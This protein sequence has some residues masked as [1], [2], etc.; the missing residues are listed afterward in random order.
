[1]IMISGLSERQ[2]KRVLIVVLIIIGVPVVLFLC[3]LSTIA[4]MYGPTYAYRVLIYNEATI[5]DYKRVFPARAVENQPPVF[6][7]KMAAQPLQI[8][9]VTYTYPPG[10][11]TTI[12]FEPYLAQSGST[13]FIVIKDD[14]ILYEKYLNGYQR[15]SINRSFSMAKSIT[16]TLVGLAVQDGY[17]HSIDDTM[18]KYLPELKGRGLDTMTIRDLLVMNSGVAFNLLP[19]DAFILTQPFYDEA[20]MY[21]MPN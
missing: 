13:A 5:E 11:T 3:L 17:I 8:G 19:R 10:N 7:F 12:D 9:K 1:M 21:Y 15:D 20:L 2:K 6:N 14:T 18:I 4:I 16:S